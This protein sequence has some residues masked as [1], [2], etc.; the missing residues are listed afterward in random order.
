VRGWIALTSNWQRPIQAAPV[1]VVERK[2]GRKRLLSVNDREKLRQLDIRARE[3]E[4]E[5]NELFERAGL[6]LEQRAHQIRSV[7]RG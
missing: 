2:A 1:E 7:R 4:A 3:I 5:I 6:N